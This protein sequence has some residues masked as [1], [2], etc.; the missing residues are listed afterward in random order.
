MGPEI[1]SLSLAERRKEYTRGGLDEAS[2]A[3]DP[4]VQFQKWF[5]Q[6]VESGVEEPNAMT[7]ATVGPK[8]RPSSR[9]VLLKGIDARGFSFYTNY[10]SRKS[11]EL[12]DNPAATLS[13]FWV[14]LERQVIVEGRASRLSAAESASYFAQRPRGSQL[15]A[16]VSEQSHVIPNRATLE[17]RLREVEAR[18]PGE[19]SMPP[20][21]GGFL[22]HPDRIEFWQ[23]RPNRL[24]DRLCYT[25]TDGEAWQVQRL[26]P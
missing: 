14:V 16:W 23:G 7:L 12:T 25:R 6:A 22:L 17:Q 11:R 13:F 19:V 24:H 1:P 5:Q 20:Y 3:A 18:F 8:G 15:G 10:E 4:L 9:V 26:A 2:L 21:W